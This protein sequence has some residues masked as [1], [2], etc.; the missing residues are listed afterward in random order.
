MQYGL[1][2]NG[3]VTAVLEATYVP[4]APWVV[5][6]DQVEP[7]WLFDGTDYTAPPAPPSEYR[8]TLSALEWVETWTADEWRTL[9]RAAAGQIPA[10]PEDV[11]KR[12]DQLLDAIK[13]TG[14]F[15]VQSPAAVV[16]Y[17]YLESQNFIDAARKAELQQGVLV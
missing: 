3:V 4:D 11:E 7:G 12:L 2:D 6:P 17:D 13:L 1:I 16:F 8:T 14:S 10:V 5:V 9:K 15:D